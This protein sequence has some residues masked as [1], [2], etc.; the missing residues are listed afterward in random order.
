MVTGRS[1]S[2]SSESVNGVGG[3]DASGASWLMAWWMWTVNSL[4]LVFGLAGCALAVARAGWPDRVGSAA[5]SKVHIGPGAG[6]V[7][8]LS[9]PFPK[10]WRRTRQ[11]SP[12]AD[13]SDRRAGLTP[14]VPATP[15]PRLHALHDPCARARQPRWS[16]RAPLRTARLVS[17]PSLLHESP[18]STTHYR[19]S[20]SALTQS[21]H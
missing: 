18:S 12:A 13:P 9:L 19:D 4:G 17:R 21:P 16:T 20:F 2:E 14:V 3:D 1:S 15:R 10:P 8:R 7:H 11:L 6:V 5:Q